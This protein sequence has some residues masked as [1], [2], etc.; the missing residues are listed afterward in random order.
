MNERIK[1]LEQVAEYMEDSIKELEKNNIP[2]FY[3]AG[4]IK[5]GRFRQVG[6]AV[7]EGIHTAMEVESYLRGNRND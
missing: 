6:I 1:R 2:G 3:F 5:T 7:G 4:D